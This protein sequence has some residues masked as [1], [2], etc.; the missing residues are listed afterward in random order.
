MFLV[1]DLVVLAMASF[2]PER[3]SAPKGRRRETDG[4]GRAHRWDLRGAGP[5]DFF[6]AKPSISAAEGQTGR[7]EDRSV[8]RL[9]GLQVGRWVYPTPGFFRKEFGIA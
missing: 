3:R 2:F 8:S 5:G 9:E 4:K 7:G 6:N 1:L